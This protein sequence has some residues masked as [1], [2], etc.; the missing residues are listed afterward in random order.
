M[1][2]PHRWQ[3]VTAAPLRAARCTGIGS[4]QSHVALLAAAVSR[5]DAVI[6]VI[7]DSLLT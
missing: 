5:M 3:I 6:C 7:G 2:S 4:A 1:R